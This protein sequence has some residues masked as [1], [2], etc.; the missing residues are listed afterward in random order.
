M[1]TTPSLRSRALDLLARR[2][3]TRAELRRK[4]APHAD[5]PGEVNELLDEL[6]RRGWLSDARFAEAL[7]HRKQAKFGVARLAREL[8]ERGVAQGVIHEHLAKLEA[9]ELKRARQVWQAKFGV[10]PEDA[11][12]RARQMRFLQSRGFSLEVIGKILRGGLEE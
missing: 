8:R 2:E 9:T 3:H 11:K 7:V 12:A 10:L 4:L 6:S 1:R 5:D